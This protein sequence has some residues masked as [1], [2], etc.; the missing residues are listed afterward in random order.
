MASLNSASADTLK[1]DPSAAAGLI[2]RGA[3]AGAAATAAGA[4]ADAAGGG[5]ASPIDVGVGT[6][7]TQGSG[8]KAAWVTAVTNKSVQRETGE[9]AG[10]AA[11]SEQEADNAARLGAIG[12][13]GA[14]GGAASPSI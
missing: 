10:V 4:A 1:L 2:G 11:L 8:L 9:S 3:S 6:L 14:A 5:G 12:P 7:R 13:Q